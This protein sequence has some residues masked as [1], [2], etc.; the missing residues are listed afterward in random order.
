MNFR[1]L[2]DTFAGCGLALGRIDYAFDPNFALLSRAGVIC[3]D[4][5]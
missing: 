2:V 4:K 1:Y 3:N 5:S